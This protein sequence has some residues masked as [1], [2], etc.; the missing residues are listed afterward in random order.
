MSELAQTINGIALAYLGDGVYETY[1]RIHLLE[2]G[3][4]KPNRLQKT[5][6]EFVSAKAQAYL[7]DQLIMTHQLSE[8]EETVYHRGRNAKSYTKAK[9]ASV[10]TYRMSTGFEALF[11]YL[12]LQHQ[13]Q[14]L[15]ELAHWC[16]TE[17]ERKQNEA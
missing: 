3:I 11:G 13:E 15:D 6:V 1:I 2:R 4:T 12:K 5:A 16:I 7:I 8:E 9:H 10:T 17:I 14:R